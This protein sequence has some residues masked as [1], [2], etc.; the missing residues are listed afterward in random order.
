MLEHHLKTYLA[1]LFIAVPILLSAQAKPLFLNNPS[2][3]DKPGY[4]KPPLGWF[5]CGPQGESPPDVHPAGL[6]GVEEQAKN[7]KTYVGMVTRD[8]GTWEAIGQRLE[9]PM[10]AGQCYRFSMWMALPQQY[11]SYS[12]V[13]GLP[14]NFIQPIIL[15]IWGGHLLCEKKALLA[16][17]TPIYHND[18]K[19]YQFQIQAEEP[20]SVI[21]LE[22]YYDQ[23]SIHPYCGSILLDHASVFMPVDCESGEMDLSVEKLGKVPANWSELE[24]HLA[25]NGQQLH[26]KLGG[27]MLEEHLYQL[28]D[29]SLQQGNLYFHRIALALN[30]FPNAFVEIR[31]PVLN[32]TQFK[33]CRAQMETQ[34]EAWEVP[35]NQWKIKKS[36]SRKVVLNLKRRE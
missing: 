15:R 17:S 1:C 13:T 4:S 20:F 31:I 5:F 12:R 24:N 16:E 21:L 14:T 9:A 29:E 23:D 10:Q 7:G 36:K 34:L 25:Q 6:F 22:A 2:F 26:L 18:W 30:A 11:N 3:E 27:R 28:P 32:G 33:K 19:Q 8:G 35:E